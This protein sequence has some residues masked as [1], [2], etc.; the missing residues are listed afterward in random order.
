MQKKNDV[1]II[2]LNYTFDGVTEK[3]GFPGGDFDEFF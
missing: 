1:S 2:P 3:E